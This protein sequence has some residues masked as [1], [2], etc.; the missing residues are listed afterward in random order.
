MRFENSMCNV[1]YEILKEVNVLKDPVSM[2]KD[3]YDD[4]IT[5][6]FNTQDKEMLIE[7]M[8][9]ISAPLR[10]WDLRSDF[11]PGRYLLLSS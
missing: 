7:Q 1:A 8:R 9:K 4:N 3:V 6:L 10:T 11:L 5:I 2:A